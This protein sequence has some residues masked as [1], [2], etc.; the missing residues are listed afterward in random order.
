MC[1]LVRKEQEVVWLAW[2]H[3]AGAQKE[4]KEQMRAQI[5]QDLSGY[6]TP[7]TIAIGVREATGKFEQKIDKI[8]FVLP[9]V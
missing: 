8:Q 1:G 6:Y 4:L 9:N 2:G 7:L 5:T 3:I